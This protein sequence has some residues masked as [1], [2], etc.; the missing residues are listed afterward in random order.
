MLKKGVMVVLAATTIGAC[1]GLAMA[2]SLQD[3][4][5]VV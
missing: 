5:S 4:K 2:G 3:R 1:P